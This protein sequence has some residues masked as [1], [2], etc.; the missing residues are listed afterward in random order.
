MLYRV[1]DQVCR[2]MQLQLVHDMGAVGL[3]GPG[4]DLEAL[5]NIREGVT[6][7]NQLEDLTLAGGEHLVGI[8]LVVGIVDPTEIGFDGEVVERWAEV[9]L[10]AHRGTYRVNHGGLRSGLEDIP[11]CPTTQCLQDV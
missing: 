11:G 4:A 8:E 5:G 9:A 2:G 10:P 3:R 7:G 1:T 6:F